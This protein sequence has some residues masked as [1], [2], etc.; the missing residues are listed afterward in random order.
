MA[1]YKSYKFPYYDFAMI[2][3]ESYMVQSMIGL[4]SYL[5]QSMI[6][7]ESYM[8]QSMIGLFSNKTGNKNFQ[9]LRTASFIG[10]GQ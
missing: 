3:L 10:W 9:I 8:V 7:L 6:G 4:E 2:G 1:P 5:V